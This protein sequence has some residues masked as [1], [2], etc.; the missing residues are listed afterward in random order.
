MSADL[1][2]TA[3]FKDG[4]IVGTR[5]N[6]AALYDEIM[7]LRAERDALTEDVQDA[8]NIVQSNNLLVR[9]ADIRVERTKAALAK[10]EAERDALRAA[11]A[12]GISLVER[13]WHDPEN[14]AWFPLS[15]REWRKTARALAAGEGETP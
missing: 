15:V 5:A 13:G 11:L 6:V 7:R 10:A 8:M 4:Y 3:I 2:L 14:P 9:D 12:E 1:D